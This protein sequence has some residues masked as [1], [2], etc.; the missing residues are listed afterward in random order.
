MRNIRFANSLKIF[1]F[2]KKPLGGPRQIRK[3]FGIF[4]LLANRIFPI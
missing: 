2:F 4:K 3:I 1:K